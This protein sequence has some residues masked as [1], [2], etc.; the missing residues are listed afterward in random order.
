MTDDTAAIQAAGNAA[1]TAGLP[2]FI[3]P[4]AQG[5]IVS[6][7]GAN[8]W[9]LQFTNPIIIFGNPINSVIRPKTGTLST[10]SIIQFVGNGGEKTGVYGLFIGNPN[11]GQ[12]DGG[13][14]LDFESQGANQTFLRPFV[15]K[16]YFATP[17]SGAGFSIFVSN[18]AANNPNGGFAYARIA[19]NFIGSGIDLQSAGDSI[20]IDHNAINFNGS[21]STNQ[22]VLA[23]LVSGAGD[24]QIINNN[25]GLDQ[26]CVEID[27]A[28]TIHIAGNE[29]EHDN[30][31]STNPLVHLRGN[32]CFVTGGDVSQ[33]EMQA[34]TGG[35]SPLIVKFDSARGVSFDQNRIATP[36]N[37]IPVSITSNGDTNII[38]AGNKYFTATTF[39]SD[40]AP[41][42][43]YANAQII[44]GHSLH[45]ASCATNTTCFLLNDLS[46]TEGNVSFI[47]Q[48]AG[49]FKNLHIS[50][51]TPGAAQNYTFVLMDNAGTTS[52]TCVISSVVNPCSDVAHIASGILAGDKWDIR[53]VTS[54]G[55]NAATDVEWSI[56]YDPQTQ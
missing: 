26:S 51:P 52:V 22:G 41:S 24:L 48:Q 8:L 34:V 15:E 55:A 21:N 2:L 31:A 36:T 53:L 5:C 25:C 28:T 1:I 37:Y 6:Q 49:Q 23:N 38:G 9:C 3:P 29:F 20:Q 13:H 19:D 10:V 33:N 14:A 50:S 47:T 32:V 12:R 30:I 16:S 39:I 7:N 40:S 27:C 17:T 35:G 56:E 44:Q 11:T 46:T 4:S 18:S 54:N 42:T 43:K 45:S